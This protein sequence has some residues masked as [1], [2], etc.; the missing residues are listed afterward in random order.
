V[1]QTSD[2]SRPRNNR[3]NRQ[4]HLRA[5]RAPSASQ[6]HSHDSHSTL[7]PYSQYYSPY[8][9]IHSKNRP[10]QAQARPA[11]M[12]MA[13]STPSCRNEL[14]PSAAH[15]MSLGYFLH[16]MRGQAQLTPMPLAVRRVR[17]NN[18]SCSSSTDCANGLLF[19]R[20]INCQSSMC[21]SNDCR[22]PLKA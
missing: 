17:E 6:A 15:R 1:G 8:T 2:I 4:P 9:T 14:C 13:P 12:P 10:G 7:Q 22:H 16:K 5:I 3:H 21:S 20:S 11:Q 18:D 19:A